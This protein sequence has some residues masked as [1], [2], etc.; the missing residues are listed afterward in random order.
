[1]SARVE[2]LPKKKVLF[3]CTH[4]EVRSLTAEHV[5][6]RRTDL[7]IRSAGVASHS[8]NPLTKDVVDWADL[9]VAFEPK[10][11][12]TIKRQFP[13]EQRRTDFVCLRL[14][15]KF[16]YKSPKL[17]IKLIARL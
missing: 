7:E 8:K 13:E 4:N 10:H 12:E 11:V 14:P 5:Y 3:V 15:D 2:L 9:V 17:V 6:R 16:E 1:M